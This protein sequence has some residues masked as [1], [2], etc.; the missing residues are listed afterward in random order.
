M[1]HSLPYH[2]PLAAP[3]QLSLALVLFWENVAKKMGYDLSSRLPNKG[4]HISSEGQVTN[5]S[6]VP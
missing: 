6:Y 1:I 4:Y 5:F 3:H 2:L